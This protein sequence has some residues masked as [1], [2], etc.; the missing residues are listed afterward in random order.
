MSTEHTPNLFPINPTNGMIFE[1]KSGVLY[2]YDSSI[3]GWIKIATNNAS[4]PIATVSTNGAMSSEDYKKLSELVI[5]PP[6]CSIVGNDCVA[7]YQR[8]IINFYSGD[9]FI[10]V[11]GGLDLRNI[12]QFGDEI[13]QSYTYKI[14]DHT[15][16]FNFTLD[17]KELITELE[18]RDQIS[19][20]G[21]QGDKGARGEQGDSGLNGILSGPK[22]DQGPQGTA[23]VND[24]SVEPENFDV[25]VTQ[26]SNKALVAARVIQ[27]TID[28]RKYYIEFDRQSV[29]NDSAAATRFNIKQVNSSWVLAINALSDSANNESNWQQCATPISANQT[30]TIYYVDLEPILN[31]I[32]SKYE[33]ELQRLKK[34]YEDIVAFW[35]RTISDMFDE[36]K[37]AIGAALEKCLS[38]TKN[39][40]LRQHMESTAATVVGR[41]KM[42]LHGRN[43]PGAVEISGTR[44]YQELGYNDK[45]KQGPKFPVNNAE[46]VRADA[47]ANE[48]RPSLL[49]SGSISNI[50]LDP[51]IN[52]SI[53]NSAK[54]ELSPGRYTATIIKTNAQVNG[55]Y[56]NNIKIR[57]IV[58]GEFNTTTFM[59]KGSY[60]LLADAQQAYN[61]LSVSFDHDGGIV[62]LYMP[63]IRIS[64]ATGSILLNIQHIGDIKSTK[65]YM[66]PK[67]TNAEVK[68]GLSCT[69]PISKLLWYKAGYESGRCCSTVIN[70]S[71]Q[72]YIIMKRSVGTD[73]SCGGG[74]NSDFKCISQFP[75]HPSFAWPTLDGL[76]LAPLP[77]SNVV[78]VYHK[79]LNDH[80]LNEIDIKFGIVL[81]PS[82]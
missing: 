29:G 76:E 6:Y 44:I 63:A 48:P 22:G 81:F 65:N 31:E 71:G 78:F 45:C 41:A 17:V 35:V 79:D 21:K 40:Q 27:D 15:Y 73:N 42:L 19:L 59:N 4:L 20:V 33:K 80:I 23:P 75:A 58:N 9:K 1:Q 74:E 60:E 77:E 28:N 38:V 51:L 16:G 82:S 24:I 62:E 43:D 10:N 54:T 25:G 36:Q 67:T 39:T 55:Q 11:D 13:N 61:G 53:Q 68:D 57:H 14:H 34:G 50:E 8:G 47:I 32:E 52:S 30:F 64:S 72:K 66:R 69:M 18:R 56:K 7:P 5:P 70:I 2:Q 37:L 3:N 26:G 12:D 49:S 46:K